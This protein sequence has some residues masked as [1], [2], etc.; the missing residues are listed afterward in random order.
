[1]LH[2]NAAIE[3]KTKLDTPTRYMGNLRERV[4]TLSPI[5]DQIQPLSDSIN[6]YVIRSPIA[7]SRKG[8]TS[9]SAKSNSFVNKVDAI[10]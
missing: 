3:N 1:M 10:F 7:Q 9:I 8:T 5:R 2:G 4:T 6:Q